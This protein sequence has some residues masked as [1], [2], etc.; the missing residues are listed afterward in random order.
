MWNSGLR[1]RFKATI[2]APKMQRDL[3]QFCVQTDQKL[4][5]FKP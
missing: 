1:E 3:S 5:C 4:R 2:K